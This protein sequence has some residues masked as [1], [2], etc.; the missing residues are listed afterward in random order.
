MERIFYQSDVADAYSGLPIYVFDTSF[1]PSPETI[2][3]DHFI[4]AM[5]NIL[6]RTPYVVVMLS[7]GLNQFNWV[8]GVKFL[9]S[10][11]ASDV[12]V[13]NLHKII[14][15]H[16]SWF[17]RSITQL[18]TNFAFSKKTTVR[19]NALFS[20]S[21]GKDDLLIRCETLSHLSAYIDI[22]KLKLSLNVYRHEAET[23]MTP[24]LFLEYPVPTLVTS[25]TQFCQ[26][27]DPDFYHHFYQIFHIVS[28]HGTQV[29]LLF[30]KPGNRLNS[31]I[32]FLCIM[33][34]QLIWINDWDLHCIAS[35][36]KRLLIEMPQR[37]VSRDLIVLPMND[38]F[39]YTVG[40]FNQMVSHYQTGA[41]LFQIID[42]CWRISQNG[43]VTKHNPR[44]I[45]RCLCFS[46]THEPHLQLKSE[47]V[48]STI[49]FLENVVEHWPKIKPLH[50]NR[51]STVESV[52]EGKD[53]H[54][55]TI[56][57]LYNMSHEISVDEVIS[58]EDKSDYTASYL[59]DKSSFSLVGTIFE[60]PDSTASLKKIA[61]A[62]ELQSPSKQEGCE[63]PVKPKPKNHNLSAALIL[64]SQ[65]ENSPQRKPKSTPK[66][67]T[68]ATVKVIA[69]H[70]VKK[71]K[72][73]SDISNVQVQW[74][75]QKYKFEKK[76]SIANLQIKEAV[77]PNDPVR[78]PVIRGRKVGQLTKLFEERSQA[79]EILTSI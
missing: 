40:V 49:R 22:T 70:E 72:R 43:S 2:D 61:T 9:K 29:E 46:L 6:P 31:E 53:F 41:V 64:I 52:V 18:V 19:L 77:K 8:W 34:N 59:S 28:T 7:C 51:F 15:V 17:V 75:P 24:K 73:L 56:D 4:P 58:D 50:R 45:V 57:E 79:M 3:Y 33:R 36:F 60:N 67:P 62:R 1:L 16:D 10:F 11:L 55:S 68:D 54:D 38:S 44:S 32:L 47:T 37:L 42:M 27:S 12:N 21:P 48:G 25:N 5:I 65:A 35:C 63:S 76:P 71:E 66:L 69:E 14:S 20:M 26:S 30:H 39:E 78:R 23:Q 13:A 74:P